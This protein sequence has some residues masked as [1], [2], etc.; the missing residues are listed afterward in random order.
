[1]RQNKSILIIRKNNE[2]KNRYRKKIKGK[3]KK[4]NIGKK[5]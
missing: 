1:M 4:E 3:Y 5:E 2:I